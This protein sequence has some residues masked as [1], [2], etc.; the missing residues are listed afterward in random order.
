MVRVVLVGTRN[1][2]N[3]G[4]A[5]RALSNFG[6]TDLVMVQPYDAAWREAK[7]AMGGK[8]LMAAARVLD[9]VQE[10]V[11]DCAL[12]VARHQWEAGC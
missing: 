5:V 9:T 12:V 2:L 10:A 4:A 7:S 3:I 8:G 11:A 6:F 1:P